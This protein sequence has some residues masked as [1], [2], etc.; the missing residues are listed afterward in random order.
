MAQETIS[1][2]ASLML[3]A[4][5]LLIH[6]FADVDLVDVGIAEH[7]SLCSRVAYPFFHASLL[8]AILNVWCLLSVVFYYPISASSLILC[9]GVAMS[10]PIDSLATL[11]PFAHFDTPT[12]GLSGVCFALMGRIS[13]MVARKWYYQKWLWCYILIGFIFPNAS[14][15]IHL[16]CY[17]CGIMI[18]FI[19]KPLR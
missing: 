17:L 2:A 19:N 11:I 10:I 15:W 7:S 6:I 13:F 8:H 18:G 12:V 5:I 9:F 16:Y 3:S 14:G 4:I 1:R